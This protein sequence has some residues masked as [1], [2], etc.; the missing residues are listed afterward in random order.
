MTTTY[1]IRTITADEFPAFT[2][3]DSEAFLEAW[4]PE[5][6]E[7][8]REVVE[9]DR[10]IVALHGEQ[11]VGSASAYSFQMT[12]PGSAVAAAGIT[13]V[14]VLPSHRRRGILTGLM[15]RLLDDAADRSE[16]V[17]ILFASEAVI[18]GRFGYGLASLH[19]RL[20]IGRGEGRLAVGAAASSP[21]AP[22]IRAVAPQAAQPELARV[23][24]T[25][26]ARRPGMLAR[27][28]RWWGY[29]LR[30]PKALRPPGMTELRCVLAED[31]DGP[32]GYALYR[33][34][35]SWGED[36]MPAGTLQ[37]RELYANDPAATAALW[38]DLLSRDLVGEVVAPMR[39][40]DDP[41][42]AMLADR[43]RARPSP[44][45]GLWVRLVDLPAAL[46]QRAY[47]AGTDLVLEVMDSVIPANSGRW[48]LQT[49]GPRA[50]AP[51][52]CER[53]T[54]PADV[55]LTVGA[56][57][58]AYLG[59]ASFGQLAGAGHIAELTPGALTSLAAAMSWDIAPYSG[60]MF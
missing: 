13:L 12:V 15:T 53:T 43:R 29:L 31:D 1:P 30:D 34:K 3:V 52:R 19:Q 41:L 45:D 6:V 47:A 37:V 40:I 54:D 55:R 17:A 32:R 10:T 5:A 46:S 2:H 8:N 22:R 48:R 42:L 9:F 16:P 50:A 58:A 7:L 36:H 51:A 18:Y 59:G 14:A 38:T 49:S 57:G 21:A 24:D 4:R 35:P 39:P 60:M 33:A 56:L 26:L 28:S 25:A 44:A 23:F 20:T 11:M 27:N